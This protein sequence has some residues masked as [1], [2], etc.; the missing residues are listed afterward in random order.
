MEFT[1]KHITFVFIEAD[2]TQAFE[3]REREIQRLRSKNLRLQSLM[4]QL[5]A[6]PVHIKEEK[7][8][9]KWTSNF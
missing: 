5:Q 9:L 8:K 7:P 3:I 2:L 1:W 6:A 4:R